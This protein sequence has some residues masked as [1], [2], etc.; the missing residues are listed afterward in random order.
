MRSLPMESAVA[1][2]WLVKQAL[3]IPCCTRGKTQEDT[4]RERSRLVYSLSVTLN[5]LVTLVA[6][7]SII[8]TCLLAPNLDLRLLYLHRICF[9]G[10]CIFQLLQTGILTLF[11]ADPLHG[12]GTEYN[13]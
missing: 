11:D 8:E 6:F 13:T 4:V 12:E 1:L 9:L 3:S 5:V 7:S 10:F 2:V